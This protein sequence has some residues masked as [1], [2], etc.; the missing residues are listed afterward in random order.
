MYNRPIPK[1]SPTCFSALVI[2][3]HPGLQKLPAYSANS[4]P[5]SIN[6]NHAIHQFPPKHFRAPARTNIRVP[7]LQIQETRRRQCMSFISKCP[8]S[9]LIYSSKVYVCSDV[10]WGG[11]C[12][13]YVQ[14]AGSDNCVT[15]DGTAS[16]IGPAPG[17]S[18]IFYK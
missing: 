9:L 12:V 10:N 3:L 7:N 14:P 8:S 16:S 4:P 13:H 11:N 17:F 18:C 6:Q 15:L 2:C 5:P 1:F